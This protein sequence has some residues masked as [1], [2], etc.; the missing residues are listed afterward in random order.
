MKYHLVRWGAYGDVIVLTPLIKYLKGEGHDI[1]VSVTERG[2]EILRCN[3][4]IDKLIVTP[5]NEYKDTEVKGYWDKEKKEVGADVYVNF[6]ES[7]EVSLL[8]HP[9]DPDYKLPKWDRIKKGSVNVYEKTFRLA[10]IDI[11]DLSD[12]DLNPKLYFSDKEIHKLERFFDLYSGL[13]WNVE[14]KKKMIILWCLSG[15]GLQ[16]AYPFIM[17]VMR[18]LI[19]KYE[20]LYFLSVGDVACKLLE[21]DSD[22]DESDKVIMKSGEWTF[23]ESMLASKYAD[24]VIS[25]DTGILHASG[26]YDTPKIGLESF[27]DIEH[28]T[29]HYKN[30][31]SMEA[32]GVTCAPCFKMVPMLNHCPLDYTGAPLCISAGFPPKRVINRVEEVIDKHYGGFKCNMRKQ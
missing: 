31:F 6:S 25:P 11:K 16:K 2:E 18:E 26:C 9:I 24:I 19:N 30:N 32:E 4:Y 20:N 3:P 5:A 29:K 1:V 15:S 13:S 27:V 17:T 28:V 7:V 21:I 12:D 14:P 8:T 10:G 23:R 22:Y